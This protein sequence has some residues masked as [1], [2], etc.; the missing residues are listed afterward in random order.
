M[1]QVEEQ[2][3]ITL[4]AVDKLTADMQEFREYAYENR[5]VCLSGQKNYTI[6]KINHFQPIISKFS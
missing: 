3:S 2:L 4:K 6:R 1:N 5:K